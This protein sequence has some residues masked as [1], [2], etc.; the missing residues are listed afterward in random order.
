MK[1]S[2][3]K[4]ASSSSRLDTEGLFS[5]NKQAGVSW[6]HLLSFLF[7]GPD[8]ANSRKRDKSILQIR[9]SIGDRCPSESSCTSTDGSIRFVYDEYPENQE[10]EKD[11]EKKKESHDVALQ[12]HQNRSRSSSQSTTLSMNKKSCRFHST[13]KVILIP[14]RDEYYEN[15]LDSILWYK[16]SDYEGFKHDACKELREF[17]TEYQV[18]SA[19][20]M[21]L[22]YAGKKRVLS[23]K[24]S[25]DQQDNEDDYSNNGKN[26]VA[27]IHLHSLQQWNFRNNTA[28][29][30]SYG[31]SSAS[32]SARSSPTF[33]SISRNSSTTSLNAG[34]HESGDSRDNLSHHL[35]SEF[36]S[37]SSESCSST[38]SSVGSHSL[39]NALSQIKWE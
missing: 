26:K 24:P 29:I 16:N 34:H 6:G 8:S 7:N 21:Q 33:S 2:A 22:L 36:G 1:D 25:S 13:V 17:M 15:S 12:A 20:A 27:K 10:N 32:S 11:Q 39:P 28:H 30:S 9:S 4:N 3:N 5:E 35:G 37:T 18:N 19:T 31:S 38:A 14:G 23:A